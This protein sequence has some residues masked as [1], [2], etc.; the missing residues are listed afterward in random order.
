[1]TQLVIATV[2]SELTP[3]PAS[4]LPA[5]RRSPARR[6]AAAAVALITLS[7]VVCYIIDLKETASLR[8]RSLCKPV[9]D[10]AGHSS[11]QCLLVMRLWLL[12]CTTFL[13]RTN[14]RRVVCT[15]GAGSAPEHFTHYTRT[16]PRLRS[17]RK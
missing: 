9:I 10:H 14:C 7:L 11:V 8:V 16:M 4:L 5:A 15:V 12:I 13:N 6:A 3:S 17:Q 2:V 1:M